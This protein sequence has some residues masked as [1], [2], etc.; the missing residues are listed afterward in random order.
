MSK[1]IGSNLIADKALSYT[2]RGNKFVYHPEQITNFLKKNGNSI[3]SAHVAPTNACNLKCS[4]CNQ[5]NRTKGAFLELDTIKDFVNSLKER[6]LKAVIVTGG[7]EPTLYPHFNKLVQWLD[8]N[9]LE[10]ALITNGTNNRCGKETVNTWDIFSWIRISLN[11]L[12]G[13]IRPLK[14]PEN[15]SGKVGFSMVYQNQSLETLKQVADVA[16]KYDA[17]YVRILPDCCTSPEQIVKEREFLKDIIKDLGSDRFFVQDKVPAQ[18]VIPECHQSKL[19]PFLLPDGT[20][21]PCDCYMLN[22]DSNGDFYKTLPSNFNLASV[23]GKPSSY[24]EYLD[25]KFKP[26]FNPIVDCNGCGFLENNQILEDM[27][28]LSKMYPEKSANEL[29]EILGM[30]QQEGVKDINFV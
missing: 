6:G 22:R 8:D 23:A 30:S 18:A 16:E 11:F 24:L 5:S 12:D 13:K 19:R 20:V 14:V 17:R 9:N 4:Y 3:I 15:L 10:T 29:F 1:I 26:D 27:I 21:A 28:R 25:G 2:S 7:G